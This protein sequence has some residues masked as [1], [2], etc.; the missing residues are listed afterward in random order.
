MFNSNHRDAIKKTGNDR[1]FCVLFSSQQQAEHL[2]RDGM[3]GD[4]FPNLYSWLRADGYAIVSEYLHTYAIPAEFNP[5]GDCQRAPISSTT[6]E[7]L[8][9]SQGTVEQEILEA[10]AQGQTG[11]HGGWVSS[12]YLDR[13]LN[14]MGMRKI[15]HTRR[16]EI[17]RTLGYDYHPALIDGRVNNPVLPDGGK[18]RLYVHETCLARQIASPNEVAKYYEDCNKNQPQLNVPFELSRTGPRRA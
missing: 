13:L 18:P 4:Y 12:I 9:A 2:T 17:L 3:Q 16:R 7:A 6:G 14:N 10:V 15:S 8:Q 11:F 1:R 5:A